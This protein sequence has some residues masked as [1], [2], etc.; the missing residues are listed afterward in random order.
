MPFGPHAIEVF[1]LSRG[2]SPPY[3]CDESARLPRPNPAC[4]ARTLFQPFFFWGS[5]LPLM[6]LGLGLTPA[7]MTSEPTPAPTARSWD[8]GYTASAIGFSLNW[9]ISE[10]AITVNS[11]PQQKKRKKGNPAAWRL[12]PHLVPLFLFVR[13]WG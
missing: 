4:F 5:Q 1:A 9:T 6:L 3:P 13:C 10:D 8:N 11:Q 7:P 2:L 12:N